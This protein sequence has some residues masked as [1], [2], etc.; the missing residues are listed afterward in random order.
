[1]GR[2][3]AWVGTENVNGTSSL[4]TRNNCTSGQTIE[5]QKQQVNKQK[6]HYNIKCILATL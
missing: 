3:A 5:Q 1:M 2:S 6:A 4:K